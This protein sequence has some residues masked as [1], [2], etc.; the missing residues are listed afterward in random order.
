MSVRRKLSILAI[1]V[2]A[3]V[4]AAASL[5]DARPVLFRIPFKINQ[6]TGD[7][8]YVLFNPFRDRSPERAATE[9]L[10]AM[11]RGNCADAA[12]V[13]TNIVLPN[14]FTCEQMQVEYPNNRDLFV[15]RFRDRT[16]NQSDVLL[17]Y[18][19]TGYEGNWVAV[20]RFSD[21]W[22]VVGFNKIW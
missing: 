11:R 21:R 16:E 15:Q 3:S 4:A 6:L 12:K 5:H 2:A 14:Q 20:R 22:R 13:S 8:N 10:D 9:Y 1:I 19:N 18:S 17:Y 7:H